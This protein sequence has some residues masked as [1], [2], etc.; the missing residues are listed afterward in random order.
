[1]G[2]NFEVI[3]KH[4]GDYS[5]KRCTTDETNM[6]NE[7][8]HSQNNESFENEFNKYDDQSHNEFD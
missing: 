3:P 5:Q 6:S 7:S 1:M 2:M 4:D 8:Q